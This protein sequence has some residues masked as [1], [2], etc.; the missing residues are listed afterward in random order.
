MGLG[1]RAVSLY[2]LP[3]ESLNAPEATAEHSSAAIG[4]NLYLVSTRVPFS[5]EALKKDETW[6]KFLCCRLGFCLG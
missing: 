4:C 5:R 3:S 6:G 2:T 1:Q